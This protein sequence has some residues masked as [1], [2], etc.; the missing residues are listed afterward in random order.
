M[1]D[2]RD[3]KLTDDFDLAVGANGDLDVCEGDD[4]VAQDSR[5]RLRSNAP[6]Y[7]HHHDICANFEDVKGE[8]NTRETGASVE[9]NAIRALTTDGRIRKD[10]LTV[11][12]VPV[13][14]DQ[15]NVHSFIKTGSGKEI[16]IVEEIKL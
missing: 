12:A 8:P 7:W 2:E 13:S 1:Y 15:I 14:L 16:S 5:D 11:R 9:Q 3:I 6:E 4:C 10:D